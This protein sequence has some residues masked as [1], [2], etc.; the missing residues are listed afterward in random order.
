MRFS[1]VLLLTAFITLSS[2]PSRGATA[3]A[4][5]F[6]PSLSWEALQTEHFTVIFPKELRTLAGRAAR[7]AEQAYEFWADKLQYRPKERTFLVLT[8]QSDLTRTAVSMLPHNVIVIDHPG[9]EASKPWESPL[10]LEALILSEYARIADQT[11]VGGLTQDLRAILG[12]IVSPG[13]LKPLFLKEGLSALALK[14]H[15]LPEMVARTL[16]Q[17]DRLPT[18]AQLSYPYEKRTWPPS[19]LQ[20]EAVGLL[21]LEYLEEAYGQEAPAALSRAYGERP[22][23]STTLG[24]LAIATGDPSHQVLQDFQA[25]LEGRFG[26]DSYEIKAHPLSGLGYQTGDPAWSPDGGAIVYFHSDPQ[27][28]AGLRLL[29]LDGDRIEDRPLIPCECGPPA[30]LDG[31]TL[32]YPKLG[33]D[34]GVHLFYDLYRYDLLHRREERL[35]YGERVYLVRPFPDGRRLL[36]ARNGRGLRS[37]LIVFDLLTRSRL[38]LKE[39][40]PTERV[41]SLALSPDGKLAV[42]SL[43]SEGRGEDL[44]LLGIDGG[45]LVPLTA[46][47]AR[48]LDP[49]FSPDGEFVL[50][51]SNREGSFD[52]YALHLQDR[53][54][55][56]I[57]RT[58]TGNFQP[59]VSPDGKKI[60]FVSYSPEGFDLHVIEYDL[61]RWQPLGTIEISQQTPPSQAPSGGGPSTQSYDP[62]PLLVPTFWLP[63]VSPGHLALF[64]RGEDPLRQH[65]YSLTLGVGLD[66]REPFYELSYLNTQR[67]PRLHL[68]FQGSPLRQRQTFMFE[69][70]FSLGLN[71]RRTLTLGLSLEPSESGIFI[72]GK[73]ED[74][75]GFDLFRRRSLLALEGGLALNSDGGLIRR[76]TLD[77][78]ERIKLP[79]GSPSG[80]YEWLFKA[81]AAWSD[82]EEFRLGGVDGPYPLRGLKGRL[83]GSQLL[84]T[85]AEYRFPVLGLEWGGPQGAAWPLFLDLL[86]GNLFADLGLVG[87]PLEFT[88]L[89]LGVGLELQLKLILGYGLAE[90]WVHLGMA[91][92]PAENESQ[93]YLTLS[94]EL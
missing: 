74:L 3:P 70:P 28:L 30:W 92:S 31:G 6:D 81:Q 7:I 13:A 75:E 20:A 67:I 94:R 19:K 80:A 89:K 26:P 8:D 64:T 40:G 32:V 50:F 44:Y 1:I 57:T 78:E 65:A 25:W 76:L 55:F 62:R 45:G 56:R 18:L 35:T 43:S 15:S 36:V 82:R 88:Q 24:A 2:L 39:F 22:L 33:T 91:Y 10:G 90:G 93:L 73:F 11:R 9:G 42:L 12:K 14:D 37:S 48:D 60:A 5:R 54:L 49:A 53:K 59:T 34:D 66:L 51:T 85:S 71:T 84:L 79:L 4:I 52:L 41:R 46:D 87:P 16:V 21:L 17:A 23:A 77:W 47:P 83:K 72:G 68:K 86:R 58:P 38:I 27:R 63:L 69:F 29:K 61:Q